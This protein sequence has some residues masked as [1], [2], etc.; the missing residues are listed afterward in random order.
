LCLFAADVSFYGGGGLVTAMLGSQSGT[1]SA[2]LP[3]L[4]L[5]LGNWAAEH[6]LLNSF[7]RSATIILND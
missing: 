1:R 2:R 7:Q 3:F 6:W 5:L 4:T